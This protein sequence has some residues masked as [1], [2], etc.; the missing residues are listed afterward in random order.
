MIAA[1]PLFAGH[2]A[3]AARSA[4]AGLG[5]RLAASICAGRRPAA[6]GKRI[7]LLLSP[8]RP[9]RIDGAGGRIVRC[10]AGRVWL[11]ATGCG[12]DVF[13]GP[14]DVWHISRNDGI[15]V[16]GI[17]HRSAICLG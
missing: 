5:R 14:G 8:N 13:L 11:T 2:A 16:E 15:L 10:I 9:I 4:L 6:T 3:V 7:E 17:D 1:K 12:D